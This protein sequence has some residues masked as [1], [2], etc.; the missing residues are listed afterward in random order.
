MRNF[1][2]ELCEMSKKMYCNFLSNLMSNSAGMPCLEV[3]GVGRFGV[4][5]RLTNFGGGGTWQAGVVGVMTAE[6]SE[7]IF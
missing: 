6:R 7:V 2:R 1:P 5:G 3:G 4:V